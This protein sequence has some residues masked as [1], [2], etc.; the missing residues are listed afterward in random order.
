MAK[1]NREVAQR[2]TAK[3]RKVFS[4]LLCGLDGSDFIQHLFQGLKNMV[5][6]QF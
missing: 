1:E 5:F 4:A 6:K 3:S 2:K